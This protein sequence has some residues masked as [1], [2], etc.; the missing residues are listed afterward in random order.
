MKSVDETAIRDTCRAIVELEKVTRTRRRPYMNW[1]LKALAK[2]YADETITLKEMSDELNRA[3]ESISQMLRM[4]D[5]EQRRQPWR[6][7]PMQSLA[8]RNA[9]IIDAALSGDSHAVIARRWGL[10]LGGVY[11]VLVDYRRKMGMSRAVW[12]R[13]FFEGKVQF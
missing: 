4:L 8:R 11:R 7:G 13:T 2:L 10:G 1:E 3:P 6:C 9:K 5:L 12:R